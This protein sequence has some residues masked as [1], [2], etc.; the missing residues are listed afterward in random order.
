[1]TQRV[2]QFE[3]ALLALDQLAAEE[4]LASAL[5]DKSPMEFVEQ[6]VVP[7]LERIG[8]GWEQGGVA[9]SQLYMSGRICEKLIDTVLPP[10]DS[11]RKEQH[12]MAITVLE[13][14]H[15]LG[16]RIVYSILRAS[17][18]TVKDY[19][20]TDVAGLTQRANEEGVKVLLIS[21]LMLPSA[22][23]IKE[24][25]PKLNDGMKVIVG[26]APF[27][28]DPDLYKEVGADMMCKNASE[29]VE[30]INKVMAGAS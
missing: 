12:N 1:M 11:R 25:I 18:F 17:G 13:D 8:D 20:R 4:I 28:F 22:L 14:Y 10:K 2:E 19:G 21:T 9:L 26:G 15:V 5:K 6:V 30:V 16:K 23:R 3:Q 7:A 24:V 29:A 27:R